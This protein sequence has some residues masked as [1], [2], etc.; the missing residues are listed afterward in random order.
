MAWQK[1][2]LVNKRRAKIDMMNIF[3]GYVHCIASHSFTNFTPNSSN[4]VTVKAEQASL[5]VHCLRKW[6]V[7]SSLVK[8]SNKLMS[9]LS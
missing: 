5:D 3:D 7:V 2:E 6:S 8:M 1:K 4:L 9:F